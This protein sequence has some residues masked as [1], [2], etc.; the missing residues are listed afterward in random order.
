MRHLEPALKSWAPR[1]IVLRVVCVQDS[2]ELCG[3]S[4][5]RNGTPQGRNPWA[6][7][8]AIRTASGQPRGLVAM[9]ASELRVVTVASAV[10]AVVAAAAAAGVETPHVDPPGRPASPPSHT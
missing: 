1:H 8:A 5:G 6:V 7:A 10:E 2:P 4:H 3:L 9:V